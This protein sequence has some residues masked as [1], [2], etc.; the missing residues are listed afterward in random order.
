MDE[1][2][3]GEGKNYPGWI[4]PTLYFERLV[5]S[6]TLV[7]SDVRPPSFASSFYRKDDACP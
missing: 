4:I 3:S 1:K 2:K 7:I 5:K 6:L